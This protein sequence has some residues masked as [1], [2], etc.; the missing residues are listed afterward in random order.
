MVDLNKLLSNKL[1]LQYMSGA[2]GALMQGEP[3]GPA[4]NQITQ[5]NIAAQSQAAANKKTLQMLAEMLGGKLAPGSSMK[6]DD[7]GNL[8]IDLPGSALT[9]GTEGM[10]EIARKQLTGVESI[11]PSEFK[12]TSPFLQAL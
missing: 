9:G 6:M 1:L 8:K 5:Q 11:T 2:G 4:L 10:R 12:L 7:K 3:I